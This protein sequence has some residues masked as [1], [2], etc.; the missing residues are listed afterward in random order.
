M[1]THVCPC[2][3]LTSN[4]WR[5]T[6]RHEVVNN[7]VH[8]PSIVTFIKSYTVLFMFLFA[9]LYYPIYAATSQMFIE[10]MTNDY[11]MP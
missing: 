10:T 7:V 1:F 9:M 3:S 11:K 6:G 4:V 8:R 2:V 5:Q